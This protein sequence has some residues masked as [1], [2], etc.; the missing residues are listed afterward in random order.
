MSGSP[1]PVPAAQE[2]A[3]VAASAGLAAPRAW[4]APAW[5]RRRTSLLLATGRQKRTPPVG[6]SALSD[7]GLGD[8][9]ENGRR[10]FRR[11]IG[12]FRADA[13]KSPDARRHAYRYPG[14]A[15]R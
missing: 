15:S 13:A 6:A 1:R 14:A 2:A 5:R 12:N 10:R 8:P 11:K 3:R 9:L 4:R 7:G